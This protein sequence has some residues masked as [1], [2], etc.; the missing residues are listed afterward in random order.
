MNSKHPL[1]KRKAELE[2]E[3]DELRRIQRNQNWIELDVP[4]RDGYEM[5]LILRGDIAHREDSWIFQECLNICSRSVYCKDK[6]FRV[7]RHKGKY[8]D[9]RPSIESISAD[10][11]NQL[12]P[13]VKKWFVEE[14]G[15]VWWQKKYT[16]TVPR[17]YFTQK[18]IPSYITHYR[19]FD[20][21]IAQRE[22]E[23]RDELD[24]N[25]MRSVNHQYKGSGYGDLVKLSNRSNRKKSKR[26]IQRNI[27][28]GGDFDSFEFG[29]DHR[30]SIGW[31]YW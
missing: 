8:E 27:E 11:Y 9:L 22:S 18:I 16:C 12:H 10:K 3:F 29:R 28:F 1:Y 26:I 14:L 17:F 30:H 5:I 19:E 31:I 4:I 7:K 25:K 15:R 2:N 23:V 6:N 20:S 21:V 13:S 24:S